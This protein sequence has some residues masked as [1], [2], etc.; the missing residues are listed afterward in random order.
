[1]APQ[2]LW[3]A[4][5]TSTSSSTFYASPSVRCPARWRVTLPD[6]RWTTVIAALTRDGGSLPTPDY[7]EV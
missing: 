6:G 4:S 1:M 7:L 3:A 5:S 2:R